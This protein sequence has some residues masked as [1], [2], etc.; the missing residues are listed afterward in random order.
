MT[1]SFWTELES[2]NLTKEQVEIYLTQK[3]GS[4]SNLTQTNLVQEIIKKINAYYFAPEINNTTTFSLYGYAREI[5][6]KQFKEGKRM[7]Q[8]YYLL[9]LGEPK[10]EKIKATKEDLPTEKWTQ[11]EQLAI[12]GKNLV[13]KYR[14]WITNKE[15]LDFYPPKKNQPSTTAKL[16]RNSDKAEPG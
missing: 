13:F 16:E 4:P 15:L 1:N 11:I 8:T 5:Q 3:L 14:K 10:G 12:L 9:K 7:G 2:K 6:T